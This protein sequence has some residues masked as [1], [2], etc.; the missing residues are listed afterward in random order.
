MEKAYQRLSLFEF[1]Q[2]FTTENQCLA[3]LAAEKWKN[4]YVCPKCGHT[5]Y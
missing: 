2:Q 1:Q 3:Y 4:G 5:H